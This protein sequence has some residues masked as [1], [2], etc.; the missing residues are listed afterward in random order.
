METLDTGGSHGQKK[1][2]DLK[3]ALKKRPYAMPS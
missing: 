1:R 2:L 3:K